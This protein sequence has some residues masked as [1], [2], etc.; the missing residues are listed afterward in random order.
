MTEHAIQIRAMELRDRLAPLLDGRVFHMTPGDR[1]PVIRQD[2]RI[3]ANH[4]GALGNTYPQ[5]RLSVGRRRGY[6]CL[7]DFRGQSET[8]IQRGLGCFLPRGDTIA[9][10][11]VAPAVYPQLVLWNDIRSIDLVPFRIPEVECWFPTDLPFSA[12]EESL[13]VTVLREPDPLAEALKASNEPTPS[14]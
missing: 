2:G 9:V 7:F 14:K 8:A 6:V 10:L 3:R 12:I 5:S 11:F 1:L 4:D 13:L